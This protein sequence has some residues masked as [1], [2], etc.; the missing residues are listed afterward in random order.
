MT[1]QGDLT[2]SPVSDDTRAGE[3]EPLPAAAVIVVAALH[4]VLLIAVA[5]RYG[6]HRDEL[7]FLE[8][9]RHLAWGYVDQPPFTPFVARVA[10]ELFDGNLVGLRLLPALATS[11]AVVLGALLVRELGGN[12]WAQVVGAVTVATSGFTLGVGHLLATATFDWLAWLGLLVIAAKLLRTGNPRWWL[13]FGAVAGVALWN[14]HLVV[15]LTVALVAGVV[16]DRRSSLLRTR[17]LLLGGGLA[18]LIPFPNLVWQV[19]NG[20]PQI[21]MA[22][23]I[24]DRIGGENRALLLPGQLILLDTAR[25]VSRAAALRRNM[26]ART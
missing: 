12:R 23:A 25:A 18:C 2:R 9:G 21:E 7:H 20:W 14:K 11:A 26:V 3:L 5:N 19:A 22:R 10:T 4:L 6:Y 17:F 8:A 16:L 15:I 24:S 13:A 1:R